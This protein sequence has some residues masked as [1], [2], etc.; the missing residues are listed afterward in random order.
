MA[1]APKYG[2]WLKRGLCIVGSVSGFV[3][4]LLIVSQ[5]LLSPRVCTS[6]VMKH[7]P[8]YID[9]KLD[10]ERVYVS[11]FRHF[12]AITANI[13]NLVITYPS[14][15]YDSIRSA[16]GKFL[17]EYAGAS[18]AAGDSLACR[19]DTLASFDRFTAAVNVLPLLRGSVNVKKLELM[20]PRAF[21]HVFNDSTANYNILKP[22]P[23]SDEDTTSGS[24][25]P[26]IVVRKLRLWDH[27]RIVY[28][29]RAD[30]LMSMLALRNLSFA[31][32]L[33]TDD[34]I[35]SR[36][37]VSMDTL[38][39]LGRYKSDTLLFDINS[40]NA[41]DHKG[42][43]RLDGSAAAYAATRAFGRLKV[44]FA[45]DGVVNLSQED[46]V[47][48]VNCRDLKLDIATIR[49][50]FNLK[51]G[52]GDRIALNG[53]VRIPELDFQTLLDGYAVNFY[54]D[55]AKIHTDAKMTARAAFEGWYDPATGEVPD[56]DAYVKIPRCR[57][58]HSDFKGIEPDVELDVRVSASQSGL[59]NADVKTL[60]V[61]SDGL[62]L[63]A[64]GKGH[65]LL[66]RSSSADVDASLAV[67]LDT[68][69]RYLN[70]KLGMT[71]RGSLSAKADG[72]LPLASFD[73]YNLGAIDFKADATVDG[74]SLVS[75]DDSLRMFL[76][77]LDLKVALMEDRFH[78]SNVAD[79]KTLGAVVKLDSLFVDMVDKL[80][81]E[82]K[83]ISIL[84]QT[85]PLENTVNDSTS[86]HP[87]SVMLSLGNVSVE[88]QD[89]LSIR[90]RN[91]KNM[92]T[93][94]PSKDDRAVP[95]VMVRSDN[96]FLRAKSGL[97]RLFL[98]NLAFD[99]K[100]RM[101]KPRNKGLFKQYADSLY[102]VHPD[103]N[104][105][106][107]RA[108]LQARYKR[109]ET[110]AWMKEEDF[111]KSDISFD[112]GET[113]RKY[114]TQWNMDGTLSMD[115]ASVATPAFP[116]RTSLSGFH[117]S[118]N[119]D[120][121]TLDSLRLR[122]GASRL[123]ANGSVSNLRNAM[124][125]KG[126][127]KARL[128]LNTDTLS[129]SELLNAYALGQKNMHTDLSYLADVDDDSYEELVTSD[130]TQLPTPLIV[131]PGNVDA[132]LRIRGKG[133]SYS[134]LDIDD[135]R[136]DV[137][138]MERC[139][140]ITG[141]RAKSKDA[142]TV[143]ADA[144]YSTE[145]KQNICAGFDMYL[146]DISASKVIE[147]MPQIDTV[148]PLLHSFDGLLNCNMAAT[149]QLDTNM[150]L[151]TPT[152]DGVMRI[153]GKDLHFNDSKEVEKIAR[154]LWFKKPKRATIDTMTV[155]CVIKDNIV[156]VFP[157]IVKADPW[158]MALAGIQNLDK[159]FS[160]HVSL[161][162]TPFL[163]KLG[164][165]ISGPDFDHIDFKLGKAMYR[166]P[167]LPSFSKEIDQSRVN[168]LHSI[169]N[170]FT[171]GVKRA[172]ME[173]RKSGEALQR[174]RE[175]AN[176][177]RSASLE[178][179]EELSGSEKAGLDSLSVSSAPDSVD[180]PST[181]SAPDSSA[182]KK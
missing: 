10:C 35:N 125:R 14:E 94:T 106:S 115:I 161:L 53:N 34:F 173:N 45:I 26:E 177:K 121:V 41:K 120:A 17:M 160:Y 66:G 79:T 82:G 168:L 50:I 24:A 5:I 6:L 1:A 133:V 145:S 140:Q 111:L 3:L 164:A 93:V 154:M 107:L 182:V 153:T 74:V 52:L 31:G 7:Y 151:I 100:A 101:N 157:F 30:T 25:L 75:Y 181:S 57:L 39:V 108:H 13:D 20:H 16:G 138:M 156:E 130:T 97:N 89:S 85:S 47:L 76:N 38:V 159:S 49:T 73:I 102:R 95:V 22:L 80:N 98:K 67:S 152:L 166:T 69:G 134:T 46:S 51:A 58:S 117:G 158:T 87:L 92:A 180:L 176:Y 62:H 169:R 23:T 146:L 135:F 9:A 104:R 18:R 37:E 165:N 123:S 136:A 2:K 174:R 143:Q 127:I 44:P 170:V 59:V 63:N 65:N 150:N 105:D 129:A 113:F 139:M 114:F 162:R 71:M 86:Y 70:D 122:S 60:Y 81:A 28:T 124:L 142:G 36:F 54:P 64:S 19:M 116:L 96:K 88:G 56:I 91:S 141:L 40:L 110:P 78:L 48:N 11:L 29:D 55:A 132:R 33:S 167:E 4:I 126:V 137:S 68:L 103:W 15:R 118:F 27:A 84:A 8:Q 147:I 61:K 90:L 175:A 163:I 179:L 178:K 131:V 72:H 83:D 172:V 144:F 128:N 32:R 21:L 148:M 171:R 77:R 112:F 42:N 99:A 149:V 119:N 109:A 155:E 43:I 12:P